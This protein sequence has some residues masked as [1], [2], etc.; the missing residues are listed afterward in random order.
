MGSNVDRVFYKY[1]TDS[2]FSEELITSGNV[3]LAT[4]R[5]LNDPFE[6]SLQDISKDWRTEQI[7]VRMEAALAGFIMSAKQAKDQGGGFYGVPLSM[8]DETLKSLLSGHDLEASYDAM[9]QFIGERTGHPPSDC[10]VLFRRIDEQLAN[11]G[12]FSMSADPAQPLMWP[13][14][15]ADHTGLCFGFREV[16]GSKLADPDHLLP[17]I[18]SDELPSLEGE[19]LRTEMSFAL[20]EQGRMYTA[21]VKVAFNDRTLQR[22]VT[23]KPTSWSYEREFRY[24]EPFGGICPWPGELAECTFG[25]RCADVRRQHYTALLKKHV[26]NDVLLFEIRPKPGTNAL[27]RVPMDPPVVRGRKRTRPQKRVKDR[28]RTYS[29]DEF[30]AKMQQLV[31]QGQYGEVM[32]QVDENLKKNP[33]DPVLLFWKATAYGHSQS[34]IKALETFRGLTE[35]HPE[36]ADA[37][38][39][40]ACALQQLGNND[41]AAKHFERAYQLE[42]NDPN[43]ALNLG[44]HLIR[45][46]S[47]WE[48]GLACLRHAE[49]L[50]HRRARSIINEFEEAR[51]QQKEAN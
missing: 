2:R 28:A 22:V 35:A 18:Y 43:H 51:R 11:T 9:R 47:R 19:G 41:A 37:W 34:H 4:A 33:S 45:N 8:V 32:L 6:C 40:M 15:A 48:E 21:G 30:A 3:F 50:G 26:P 25:L 7:K 16:V 29:R 10:R 5:Q 36:W 23:T 42:P 27:I 39:G 13:H 24:I 44:V 49:R 1:R 31:Q 17:V 46:P 38:Y 14:Y 20:D 12:I